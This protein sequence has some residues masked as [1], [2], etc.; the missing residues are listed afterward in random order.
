MVAASHNE[1]NNNKDAIDS[2][3]ELVATA[4]CDFKHQAWLPRDHFEKLHEVRC[5]NH[6]YP[7]KHKLKEC[8]MMKNYKTMGSLA[9]STKPEDDSVGK[10]AAPSLVEKAVMSIYGR[11]A[12]H[13]S[14]NKLKLNGRAINSMSAA[15]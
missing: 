2:N 15:V 7:V 3:E 12:L 14:R 11:P 8:T 10:A 4:E 9:R 5:P 13:E 1:D 6:T